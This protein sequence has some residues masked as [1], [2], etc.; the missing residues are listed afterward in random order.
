MKYYLILEHI[1]EWTESKFRRGILYREE[2]KAVKFVSGN[3]YRFSFSLS[4]RETERERERERERE[5]L[6]VIIFPKKPSDAF[7]KFK[8]QQIPHGI[9]DNLGCSRYS[10]VLKFI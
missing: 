1:A 8:Y 5:Y 9:I 6:P 2:G 7:S 10:F 3:K 4:E